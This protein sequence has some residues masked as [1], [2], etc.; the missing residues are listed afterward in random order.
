MCNL[1][2]KKKKFEKNRFNLI[3]EVTT[4]AKY[5]KNRL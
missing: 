2:R 4:N 5:K 1:Q 3:D